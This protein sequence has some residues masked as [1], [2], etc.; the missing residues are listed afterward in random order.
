MKVFYTPAINGQY[1]FRAQRRMNDRTDSEAYAIVEQMLGESGTEAL[2][3][4]GYVKVKDINP[5]GETKGYWT[6][7]QD[8]L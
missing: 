4:D 8:D 6:Y 1:D 7:Q 3:R 2:D 5:D